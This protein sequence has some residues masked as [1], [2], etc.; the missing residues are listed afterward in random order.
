M[1][2]VPSPDGVVQEP[3]SASPN[4][5]SL[6]LLRLPYVFTQDHVWRT[7]ELLKEAKRRGH[8]VS[9]STL[10]RLHEHRLL[11]PLY[12]LADVAVSG[13]RIDIT[14]QDILGMN[15]RGWLLEAAID[16]RLRDP[17]DEGYCLAWPYERP[18]DE[19]D[20]RWWN[21]FLFSSWQVLDLA[22]AL[23]ELGW[24]EQGYEPPDR[25]HRAND[26]RKLTL[27]LAALSGRH[28]ANISGQITVPSGLGFDGFH[29]ARIAIDEAQRLALVTYPT[30]RLL[31]DAESLLEQAHSDPLIDWWPVIRH[32]NH[33]GWDKIQGISAHCLWMRLG[34][35]V[36]LRAHEEVAATGALPELP[37]VAEAT[38]RSPLHDRVVSQRAGA[39]SLERALG[40]FGL[41][42]HP[43][44]LLLLEGE[45]EMVHFPKLLSIFGL[46]LPHL[47]RL[48]NCHSSE[49]NP[50][51]ITRYA[52]APRLAGVR[53]TT[54]MTESH[55][56][57]LV[58]AMDPE[59]RWSDEDGRLA[60]R[61]SLQGAI[62]QEVE[63]QGGRIADVDLDWLVTI[64]VWGTQKYELAN[65]TDEEL[66]PAFMTLGVDQLRERWQ[67]SEEQVAEHLRY[68]R[69]GAHDIKVTF[70][71][72]RLRENKPRLAELLWP[73]LQAKCEAELGSG[74]IKTPALMVLNDVRE[75]A[76]LNSGTHYSLTPVD[77]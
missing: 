53:G 11:M 50:Q 61:R 73:A 52:I 39:D 69:E 1:T 27:A 75:K 15:P 72:L 57:C 33:Q 71:R 51:L 7:D 68:T 30:D 70:G 19:K 24:L 25:A 45:T 23:Q 66:V 76:A 74:D 29:E 49:V 42:P 10:Q 37:D 62:R 63:A 6:A 40:A 8:V 41:L 54:Q 13:R 20:R 22:A 34:A 56:T 16:G 46:N 12:R 32:A 67:V 65:F 2:A 35:E 38:W 18:E 28:L 36:L 64:H 14:R 17:A 47:V 26:R 21:G 59:N 55:P 31:P 77:P 3:T 5:G 58:V 48:Q 9:L 4:G 44:V 60:E 43:R